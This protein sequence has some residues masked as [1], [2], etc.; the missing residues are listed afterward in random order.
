[1]FSC[2]LSAKINAPKK[3]ITPILPINITIINTIFEIAVKLLVKPSDNPVLEYALNT[4]NK[5]FTKLSSS[6]INITTVVN[7]VII[8]LNIKTKYA[9]LI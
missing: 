4:S 1:M 7:I 8:K 3:V 6:T 2:F 5:T 9:L